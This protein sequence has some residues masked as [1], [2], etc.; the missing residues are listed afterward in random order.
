MRKIQQQRRSSS[1]VFPLKKLGNQKTIE[2]VLF[3]VD[4]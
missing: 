1:V 2:R 3:K 4:N